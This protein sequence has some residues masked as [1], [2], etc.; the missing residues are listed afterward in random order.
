M[1]REL[2][3]AKLRQHEAELKELGVEHLYLFGCT[4]RDEAGPESDVDLFFDQPL[5]SIGLYE[6]IGVREAAERILGC[7]ADIMTRRSL[8]RVLRKK[9]EATALPV[10]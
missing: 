8:H 3:L 6:L 5:G 4:A 9:I 2:A 10:F 7:R 1:D